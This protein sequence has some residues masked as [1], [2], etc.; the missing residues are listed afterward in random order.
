MGDL[1][2]D[3]IVVGN[4]LPRNGAAS[5]FR[6]GA[7]NFGSPEASWISYVEKSFAVARGNSYE[8]LVEIEAEDVLE[9]LTGQ[10][11]V[12]TTASAAEIAESM[13]R[14]AVV[15]G[16]RTKKAIEWEFRPSGAR[17]PVSADQVANTQPG[18]WYSVYAV[19]SEHDQRG[20][21]VLTVV[22]ENPW[23]SSDPLTQYLKLNEL[24]FRRLFDAVVM[25]A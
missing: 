2:A 23:G 8:N 13:R 22:L 12:T 11:Y 6:D 14:G 7:G 15:A 4:A 10:E 5:A 25:R 1:V 21:E 19:T 3:D 20:N 17:R 9:G 16:T 18:H 24:D